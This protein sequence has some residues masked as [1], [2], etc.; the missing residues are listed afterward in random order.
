MPNE[1]SK[2]G[3]KT[4]ASVVVANMI[5]TG[6]F[7]SL[8]FQLAD[9]T[10]TWSIII[11]WLIGGVI[12]LIGAFSYAELGTHFR[13]SGGDYIF[14]SKIFHPFAGYIYA[15][16][17]LVVGFSAPIAISALAMTS[18]LSPLNEDI[19]TDWFGIAIIIIVTLVHSVSIGQSGK[20][21]NLST[22]LKIGFVCA[23]I[24]I[25]F[26]YIPQESNSLDFS[27]SWTSEWYLPAFAV[28]LIYVS[29]A[30][31]GWNSAAYIT[32]EIENPRVNLPKAL[33]PATL[34]VTILYVLLQ[35]VFLRHASVEQMSGQV[36]VATISF[37]N[38]FSNS[39]ATWIPVFIG[40]Q[41]VATISGYLW[42]GSRISYAMAK[43]NPLWKFLVYENKN[44]IPIRSLWIQAAIAIALT[45][46]GTFEQV[47]L[48]AS[49]SLQL[50]G[51]LTVAS[52]LWLKRNDDNYHSPGRPFLQIIYILFS[53]WVLSFM[54]LEQPKESFIGLG[55]VAV[56]AMTY[57]IQATLYGNK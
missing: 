38:V 3:W 43:E 32:G 30:Y 26:A 4:A 15:W 18:Y 53:V 13:E 46:T 51:T 48:Y 20:F 35:L 11:L 28:S 44:G 40:I 33:I 52:V 5:G 45:L 25:G 56:G 14:L 2:I 1:Q 12:A 54:L 37:S 6:V 7:T 50:M 29:Y 31:T 16:M 36:E 57:L 17:S 8:G 27:N 10:N 39:G 22:I 47:L 23:L 42:V 24:A 34:F 21:Q 49:F 9:I 41:L 55:I 19:F